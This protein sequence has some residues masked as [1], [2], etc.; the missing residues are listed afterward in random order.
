VL[1][2]SFIKLQ[3]IN[4]FTAHH[5]NEIHDETHNGTSASACGFC[6]TLPFAN[7]SNNSSFFIMKL[8][9]ASFP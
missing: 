2:S 8:Q 3:C 5:A 9:V 6:E 7:E 4:L 1:K